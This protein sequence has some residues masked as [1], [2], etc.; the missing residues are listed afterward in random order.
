MQIEGTTKVYGLPA[1][2]GLDR[3]V[4]I[5]WPNTIPHTSIVAE[6]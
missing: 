5:A 1:G 4:D 2:Q 6:T 3:W